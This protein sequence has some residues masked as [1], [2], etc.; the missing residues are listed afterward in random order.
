MH[1]AAGMSACSQRC[2]CR[3]S[4]S[5]MFKTNSP[6]PS[7]TRPGKTRATPTARRRAGARRPTG[8]S[9]QARR[10]RP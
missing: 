9:R 3:A 1:C 7:L 8:S 6:T 2:G 4:G 10:P 5:H